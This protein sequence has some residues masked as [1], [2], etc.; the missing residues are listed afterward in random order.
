MVMGCTIGQMS[1]PSSHSSFRKRTLSTSKKA[2]LILFCS[3]FFKKRRKKRQIKRDKKYLSF[4]GLAEHIIYLTWISNVLLFVYSFSF[5]SFVSLFL[6]Y[7]LLSSFSVL[8][9][10]FFYIW[11]MRLNP[12]CSE[13]SWVDILICSN[14]KDYVIVGGALNLRLSFLFTAL[15]IS[16]KLFHQCLM[17]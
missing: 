5:F 3:Y 17:I 1:S 13:L 7:F 16:E 11:I 9:Y 6:S 4:R 8:F 15:S 2:Q 12:H 10:S 14:K